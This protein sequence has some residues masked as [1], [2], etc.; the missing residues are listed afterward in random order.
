M[1]SLQY[2]IVDL[3]HTMN[4]EKLKEIERYHKWV[5]KLFKQADLEELYHRRNS[6]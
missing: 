2:L 4:N 3:Y 6:G 5:Y 1:K